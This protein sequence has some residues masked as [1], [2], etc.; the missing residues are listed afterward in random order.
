M[1]DIC[2]CDVQDK[3]S[4]AHF[5]YNILRWQEILAGKDLHSIYNQIQDLIW[6]WSM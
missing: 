3:E 4:I 1:I 6:N 5:R 2:K